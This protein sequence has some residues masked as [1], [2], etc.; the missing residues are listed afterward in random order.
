MNPRPAAALLMGCPARGKVQGASLVQ[1][2]QLG[3]ALTAPPDPG[4]TASRLPRILPA[5]SPR[6][7]ERLD[8]AAAAGRGATGRWTA[9]SGK[10]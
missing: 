8:G 3:A 1:E 5:R 7:A 2:S 4:S 6:R 10:R 9:R